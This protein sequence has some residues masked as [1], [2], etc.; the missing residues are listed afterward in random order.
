[1][2]LPAGDGPGGIY[3]FVQAESA[4]AARDEVVERTGAPPDIRACMHVWR[5]ADARIAW[6]RFAGESTT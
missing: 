4:D 3:W 1:M 2:V 6:L 5:A